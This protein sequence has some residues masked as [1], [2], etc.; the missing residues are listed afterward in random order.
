M[1][2]TIDPDAPEHWLLAQAARV[3]EQGGLIVVPTDTVYAA[4][5]RVD[6]ETAVSRLY[7]MKGMSPRKQLSILCQNL[8]MAARFT[9]GIPNSLFRIVR[10]C[11]PGPYTFILPAS[12]ALP[13]I[14]RK[15]RRTIGV[16]IPNCPTVL[17]LIGQLNAPLLTTSVAPAPGQWIN[18]P[19]QIEAELGLHVDLVIDGG[20][21]FPEPST[22]I[23]FTGLEPLVIREGK[24]PVD[25]L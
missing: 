16:R 1:I 21:L 6:D 13:R 12:K 20:I 22:V 9:R 24:G 18:D 5:C 7:G 3:V 19:V 23:D 10:R 14:M 17:D 25:F 2:L 11:L 8:E 4:A 15:D